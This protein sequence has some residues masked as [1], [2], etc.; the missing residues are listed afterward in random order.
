MMGITVHR[1]RFLVF[2]EAHLLRLV[3]WLLERCA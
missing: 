2:N 3:K 1:R